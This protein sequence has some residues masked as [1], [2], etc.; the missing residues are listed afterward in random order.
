MARFR[1]DVNTQTKLLDIH[2]QFQG[3]LKTVDTDDSLRTLFLRQ[4]ENLELSEYGFLEK[5]YG[6]TVD[7]ALFSSSI[8]ST[9]SNLQGYFEYVRDDKTIDKILIIDGKLFLNTND[10][11]FT[12]VTNIKAESGK[13]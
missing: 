2:K 11:G 7:K 5:R 9:T 4:A 1:Y 12:Q 6:Q 10:T 3:G 8:L 13:R